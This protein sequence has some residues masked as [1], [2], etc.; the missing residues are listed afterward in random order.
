M[1]EIEY[2]FDSI[3][4]DGINLQSN[5]GDKWLGDAMYQPVLAELNRR[6]A[7]VYVH[8]L[9]AACCGRLAIPTFPAV[10][11][12]PH[13]TTRTVTSLLL[14]GSFKRFPDIKW[15]FSHAGGTIPLMAGRIAAFY[16]Q[17]PKTKEFAPNGVMAELAKLHYDT[18]NAT[19]APTIAAL[20]KLVPVSQVTYGTDYPYF[21]L[22]QNKDLQKLG[23]SAA[24]VRRDRERQRDAADPAA[25]GISKKAGR[26]NM[27]KWKGRALSSALRTA[28]SSRWPRPASAAGNSLPVRPPRGSPPRALR[29]RCSRRRNRTAS[30]CTP[31]SCRHPGSTRWT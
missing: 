31:I 28:A 15:I 26:T 27:L 3:K 2:A 18:A 12:V 17:N 7:V 6:K 8:P 4:A 20:L 10:I 9:V 23:L 11:E 14:T 19:S 29:R 1:K 30:T 24:D 21:A 13:D 5:Y 16:D 22:N 25:E